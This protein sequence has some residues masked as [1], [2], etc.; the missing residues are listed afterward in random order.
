VAISVKDPAE[1][2]L[3]KLGL[4]DI[5]DAETGETVTLLSTDRNVRKAFEQ[6]RSRQ[7]E[8]QRKLF[9]Q[10][11]VDHIPISTDE[12]FTPRLHKFFQERARRYR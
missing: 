6:H 8:E 9:R 4:V 7:R 12:D 3:P 5:E 10:L 1:D 11:G 2:E